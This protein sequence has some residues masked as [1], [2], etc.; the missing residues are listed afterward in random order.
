MNATCYNITAN[1]SVA[2]VPSSADW[3]FSAISRLVWFILL[4][5]LNDSMLLFLVL[6][7][8][9]RTGFNVYLI[10]LLSTNVFYGVLQYPSEILEALYMHWWMSRGA[11]SLSLYN[12]WV[13]DSVTKHMH[14]LITVNR[15]WA[16]TFPLSYRNQHNTKVACLLTVGM[17]S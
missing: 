15:L 17:F 7:K 11:C 14:V 4:L 3:N 6:H 1:A 12:L 10:G 16:L 8:T 5:V 9:L 2:A 13:L